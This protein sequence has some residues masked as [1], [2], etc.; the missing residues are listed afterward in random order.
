MGSASFSGDKFFVDGKPFFLSDAELHYFRLQQN[1]WKALFLKAK[2]GRLIQSLVIYHGIGMNRRKVVLI[3]RKNSSR[4][5][6]KII[7]R[8]TYGTR[9]EGNR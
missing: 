8:S 6:F 5:K 4:K 2:E 7:F 9:F 3:L 1:S